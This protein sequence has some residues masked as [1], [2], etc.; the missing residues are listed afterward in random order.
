MEF[1]ER[2]VYISKDSVIQ[3]PSVNEVIVAIEN[4]GGRVPYA[5]CEVVSAI[6]TATTDFQG[7]VI[8]NSTPSPNFSSKENRGTVMAILNNNYAQGAANIH[9]DLVGQGSK[10]ILFGNSNN[11]TISLRQGNGTIIDLS[12]AGP[13]AAFNILL[14]LSYPKPDQIQNTYRSEVPLPSKV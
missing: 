9:Y 5:L 2:Y 4:P 1:V 6:V 11:L 12:N 3:S 13:V 7:C 10:I 8:Y 14:K